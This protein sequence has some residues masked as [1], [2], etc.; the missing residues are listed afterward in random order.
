M[1][2]DFHLYIFSQT[3]ADPDH[4]SKYWIG[5]C[6]NGCV[7]NLSEHYCQLDYLFDT[8]HGYCNYPKNVHCGDRNCDGRD[9]NQDPD[10]PI[11]CTNNHFYADPK[12]CIKYYQCWDGVATHKTCNSSKYD[13]YNLI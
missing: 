13:L 10:I 7:T 2:Y 3:Y 1:L 11:D 9:C 8:T 12:N 5:E 4:C 6:Y